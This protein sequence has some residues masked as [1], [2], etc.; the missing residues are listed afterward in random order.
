MQVVGPT[1][2]ICL[3][4][5]EYMVNPSMGRLRLSQVNCFKPWFQ[6]IY[7]TFE[8][9]GLDVEGFRDCWICK[10]EL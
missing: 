3:G 2:R 9:L 8:S 7:Y 5:K 10:L 4:I 1:P 6:N